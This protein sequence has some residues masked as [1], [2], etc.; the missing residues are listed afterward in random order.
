MRSLNPAKQSDCRVPA[1]WLVRG[2]G[3]SLHPFASSLPYNPANQQPRGPDAHS[4]NAWCGAVIRSGLSP[5]PAAAPLSGCPIQRSGGLWTGPGQPCPFCPL[6]GRAACRETNTDYSSLNP[7]TPT[8]KELSILARMRKRT[9]RNIKCSKPQVTQLMRWQEP[10]R[11]GSRPS[12]WTRLPPADTQAGEKA[13]AA[14]GPGQCVR[15]TETVQGESS[16]W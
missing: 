3:H 5:S 6:L 7:M 2:R 8:E 9:L 4:A 1:T 16:S 13:K 12:H 15:H 11:A 14:V 10:T